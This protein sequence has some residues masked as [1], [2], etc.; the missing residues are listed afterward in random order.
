M[1]KGIY[2]CRSTWRDKS[3]MDHLTM[4]TMQYTL[5]LIGILM[6]FVIGAFASRDIAFQNEMRSKGIGF[7]PVLPFPF[8][9]KNYIESVYMDVE[10]SDAEMV[11]ALELLSSLPNLKNI[12]LSHSRITDVTV[13]NLKSISGL[14]SLSLDAT[15]ITDKSMRCVSNLENLERLRV[16]GTKITDVG[17]D[18]V[19]SLSRLKYLNVAETCVTVDKLLEMESLRTLHTLDVSGLEVPPD[20]LRKLESFIR[21]KVITASSQ[22]E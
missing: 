22:S 3:Q 17:I 18:H 10:T 16:A 19:A 5:G 15:N 20:Q 13:C 9:S 12:K 8:G 7:R 6:L 1:M 2:V 14:N 21:G 4:K 11:E